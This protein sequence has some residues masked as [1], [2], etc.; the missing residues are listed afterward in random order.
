M[1]ETLRI[2][3]L[4]GL[5]AFGVYKAQERSGEMVQQEPT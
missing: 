2:A 1:W 3:A 4:T 5:V